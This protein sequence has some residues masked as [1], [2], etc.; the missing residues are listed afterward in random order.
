MAVAAIHNDNWRGRDCR[1]GN[2]LIDCRACF[3]YGSMWNE[4]LVMLKKVC[5]CSL[6]VCLMDD[7]MVVVG[8]FNVLVNCMLF[9]IVDRRKNFNSPH[10]RFLVKDLGSLEKQLTYSILIPDFVGGPPSSG[11]RK[12]H[13]LALPVSMCQDRYYYCISTVSWKYGTILYQT[14]ISTI[15][16]NSQNTGLIPRTRTLGSGKK[17]A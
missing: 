7:D 1:N 12:S 15:M 10:E 13:L 8:S 14:G 16:E 6:A 3:S 17:E 9:W 2:I 4:A 11:V 5:W